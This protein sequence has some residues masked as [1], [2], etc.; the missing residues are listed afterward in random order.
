VTWRRQREGAGTPAG[1]RVGIFGFLGSGN[2]GNDAAFEVVLQY[3]RREHPD[4]VVDAM[5]MGPER[6]RSYYGIDAVPMLWYKQY[7]D[8][9]SPAA[10]FAIKVVGKA[11]AAARTASW[12]RQ[13]DVVIVPGAGA[14][15]ASL[16]IRASG[17]PY[18]MFLMSG[19]GRL[20]GTKV[21]LV[22]VG[23]NRINKRLTRWLY[24]SAATLASYRSYRDEQSWEAMRQRGVDVSGDGVYP[25]LVF[26]QPAPADDP[27]DARMVG[28]G[29][30]AY[31]GGNDD[32]RQ[33][34]ELHV[35]YMETIKS[36]IRWLID[37]GHRVRLFWGDSN[38]EID[39][40]VVEEILADVR[41]HRPEVEADV[42][43]AEPCSSP[44]EL[45]AALGR[46]GTFVGTRYHNIVSALRLSVPTISIGYSAKFEALMADMGMSKFCQ[47]ARAVDLDRLI[48]QYLEL[49]RRAPELRRQLLER[50]RENTEAL[51][52]QF[53]LL[54]SLL[55]PSQE[56][57]P[58]ETVSV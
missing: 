35:H 24:N 8:D 2:L 37:R 58:T 10:A 4:A 55:F 7:E 39:G 49:E 56:P 1:R 28:V 29:L 21:A 40:V 36:F 3:L 45:M 11:V 46:V 14:L 9:K 48:E 50:N 16:P 52:R 19:S 15:E 31:Y 25:D 13:H 5:C 18:S 57:A 27:G 17:Y 20:F 53:T 47:P 32:R 12:V 34:E 44:A 42:I 26:G 22:S 51:D 41:A 6:L 54:S 30:M 23:A 33:A 38:D 43:V